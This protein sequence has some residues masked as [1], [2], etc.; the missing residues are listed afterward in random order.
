M[1]KALKI[2]IDYWTLEI[3]NFEFLLVL[4]HVDGDLGLPKDG[5]FGGKQIILKHNFGVRI[6]VATYNK[7]IDYVLGDTTNLILLFFIS[8]QQNMGFFIVFRLKFSINKRSIDFYSDFH[9]HI[10]V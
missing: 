4:N 10:V 2:G 1:N 3:F 9:I 5:S 8:F 6:D 7:T